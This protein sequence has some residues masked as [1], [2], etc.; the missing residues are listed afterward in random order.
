MPSTAA[1]QNPRGAVQRSVTTAISLIMGVK[2]T[3]DYV[4]QLNCKA[5]HVPSNAV[6]DTDAPTDNAGRGLSFSPTDLLGASLLSCALTTMAIKGGKLGIPFEKAS[7]EVLKLMHTEGPR[8]VDQ[9][10]VE[11]NMPPGLA[12]EARTQLETIGKTCPVALSLHP[13][14]KIPISFVYAD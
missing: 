11:I 4:G 2:M 5:R 6:L 7:G 9:L 3:V 12:S 14:L 1:A 8:R 13:D 10:V